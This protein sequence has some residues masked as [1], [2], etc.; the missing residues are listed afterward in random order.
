MHLLSDS[1]RRYRRRPSPTTLGGEGNNR[2]D[3]G[4]VEFSYRDLRSDPVPEK[5]D[6]YEMPAVPD[7]YLPSD[8]STAPGPSPSSPVTTV[9]AWAT[10]T[11]ST[12]AVA[13]STV[14]VASSEDCAATEIAWRVET[15]VRT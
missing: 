12:A 3:E 1:S 11:G 15:Q 6:G 4:V 2:R 7:D 10:T 13:E 14:V 9:S 5:Y 8:P